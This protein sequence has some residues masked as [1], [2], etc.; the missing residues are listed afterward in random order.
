MRSDS[1]SVEVAAY[2]LLTVE[3]AARP[4]R[5]G[6]SKAYALAREY[7]DSGGTSGL[8]V[9]VFGPGCFRVPRWALIGSR[10]AGSC[11]CV[12]RRLL[13]RTPRLMAEVGARPIVDGGERGV[14]VWSHARALVGTFRPQAW[15]VLHDLVFDAEWVDDRWVAPSSARRVAEHLHID[16][17]TAAAALRQLRDGGIAEL[18]QA[19]G[20]AGRFGLAAYTLRLPSGIEV[21]PPCVDRPHPTTA[22]TVDPDTAPHRASAQRSPR[23]SGRRRAAAS[24]WTQDALDLGTGDG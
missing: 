5:I 11:G 4:M 7:L 12:T 9:I 2:P 16:P 1:D 24:L 10:P 20:A 22:H 19:S 13:T 18:T 8:P 3:E 21:V 15:V 14:V 23:P 17:G 6:R